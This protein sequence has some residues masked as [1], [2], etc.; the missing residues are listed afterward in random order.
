MQCLP[1]TMREQ[2]QHGVQ[3]ELSVDADGEP[4]EERR[5]DDP[6]RAVLSDHQCQRA[7]EQNERHVARVQGPRVRSGRKHAVHPSGVDVAA[8]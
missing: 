3:P 6:F 4:G 2:D 8:E 7:D 1:A 5:A